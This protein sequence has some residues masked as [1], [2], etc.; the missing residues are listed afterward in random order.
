MQTLII[1]S[2]VFNYNSWNLECKCDKN[3]INNRCT[4]LAFSIIKSERLLVSLKSPIIYRLSCIRLQVLS[5]TFHTPLSDRAVAA[6]L[7]E[8]FQL[9]SVIQPDYFLFLR[10]TCGL[11]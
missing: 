5:N 9:K 3:D 1:Y 10:R 7:V 11:T 4:K 2:N 8:V 6:V